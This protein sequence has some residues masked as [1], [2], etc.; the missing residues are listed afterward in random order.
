MRFVL[1]IVAFFVAAVMIAFGIAQR[2]VLLA[3]DSVSMAT[4]VSGGDA[5]VVIGSKTLAL[6]PG[7]Q[8]V[9]VSGGAKTS[10]IALGR[11]ADVAAWIEGEPYSSIGVDR[12]SGDLAST[13]VASTFEATGESP[14]S[15]DATAAP[16]VVEPTN[17]LGSDLWLDEF[18]GTTSA[19]AELS[20]PSGYSLLVA[21]D[22]KNPAP[23]R[24]SITWPL[25]NSTP[26]AGPLIV[27]GLFVLLL[28]FA[29]YLWAIW[30]MRRKRRPRRNMPKGP[31][32][33]RI[34]RPKTIKEITPSTGRRAI[35]KSSR[36]VAV[37]I[38]LVGAL[39]LS[40]CSSEFWPSFDGASSP[41]TST[42]PTPAV[43]TDVEADPDLKPPAVT[44]PQL[45]RIIRKIAVLTG[46]ADKALDSAKL[47]TRFVGPA[48]A[49]REANYKVRTTLPDYAAPDAIP[50]GP[51]E[52]AVP[53]QTDAWPR[54]V[55][56]VLQNKDDPT[57]K[58][59]ALVLE[60]E[61][62][63]A[64]YFVRYAVSL[65]ADAVIPGMAPARI[66]SPVVAPDSEFTLLPPNKVAPAYADIMM[67]GD[68]SEW[69]K[70]FDTAT[71]PFLKQV[72][73]DSK[74]NRRANLP[75]TA[76]IDFSNAVGS[77]RTLALATNDSG[78]IVTVNINETE[79]VKPT[80]GGTV[81]PQN[82]A[83]AYSGVENSAKGITQ[84]FGDQ[85][86]FYVPPAGSKD[87]IR[88][89]G[90]AQGIISA[91]EVP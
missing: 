69:F 22:G 8:K 35:G 43:T 11:E 60:Q 45:E 88:M 17:P 67:K 79:T 66:G 37:P 10:M 50:A 72:G 39:A 38:V 6:H 20:V 19:S 86:L 77:G 61:S 89:L 56:T 36:V 14:A 90:F 32:M 31:R 42:T 53:Q 51:V 21:S 23:T 54:V 64:N 91:S 1:A 15:D 83:K 63:R 41:T 2:T 84:T 49:L 71:D 81:S 87:T 82:A 12:K 52:L 33:P 40:G 28:G 9:Q 55:M 29:S 4:T 76:S 62:P 68:A 65:A 44:V 16:A 27:G 26:W 18:A 78:A 46:E 13:R 59:T 5:Y 74:N 25:D 47:A 75:A 58:P 85:V 24:V 30:H 80:D 48:L 3:P 7:L 73:V 57:T 34:P 70:Y